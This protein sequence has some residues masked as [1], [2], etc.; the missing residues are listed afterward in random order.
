[1]TTRTELLSKN[2]VL[3]TV[4]IVLVTVR[5]GN[6]DPVTFQNEDDIIDPPNFTTNVLETWGPYVRFRK[7]IRVPSGNRFSRLCG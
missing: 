2:K 6:A 3:L 4:A 1:M 7:P 5:L